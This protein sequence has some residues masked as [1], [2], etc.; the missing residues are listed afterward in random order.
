MGGKQSTTNRQPIQT[1][2]TVDVAFGAHSTELKL[3]LLT[4]RWLSKSPS[5]RRD[6]S[7]LLFERWTLQREVVETFCCVKKAYFKKG[8]CEFIVPVIIFQCKWVFMSTRYSELF[9]I[10]EKTN[11]LFLHDDLSANLE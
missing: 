8:K 7:P 1:K 3:P 5:F 2:L 11:F 4:H 10:S 9:G 6:F